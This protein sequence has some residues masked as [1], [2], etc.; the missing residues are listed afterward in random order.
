MLQIG[1]STSQLQILQMLKMLQIGGHSLRDSKLV[2]ADLAVAAQI[3]TR[4][5][6]T[7]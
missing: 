2:K 4:Q 5:A 6:G 7:L 3:V 1:D